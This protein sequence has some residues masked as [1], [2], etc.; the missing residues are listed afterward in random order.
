MAGLSGLTDRDK[1][2]EFLESGQGEL[3]L[4]LTDGTLFSWPRFIASMGHEDQV[5]VVGTGITSFGARALGGTH[6]VHVFVVYDQTGPVLEFWPGSKLCISRLVGPDGYT[7][8]TSNVF[9]AVKD[10]K[11]PQT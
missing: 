5:T 2:R 11:Q 1:A 8:A 3:A 9:A 6:D 10:W 7:L 4:D